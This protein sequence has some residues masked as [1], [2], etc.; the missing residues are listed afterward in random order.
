MFI[1]NIGNPR[2]TLEIKDFLFIGNCDYYNYCGL[3]T[4]ANCVHCYNYIP[5]LFTLNSSLP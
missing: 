3:L 2:K 1:I 4:I 5:V